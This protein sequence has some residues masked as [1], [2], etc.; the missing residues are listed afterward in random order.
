MRGDG[1]FVLYWMTTARRSGWNFGLQHAANLALELHRPLVILEALR[2]DY[3]WAS[4]R[5]H[6]FVIDGMEDNAA[7]FA[8]RRVLY[9]C[10][11][12]PSPGAG[13]GLI[14]SLAEDA[15]LVV[16]D[17]FPAFF[18]PRMLDAVESR[19]RVRLERVDSNGLLPIR[20]TNR[21]F[22]VA[23]SFRRYL[24]KELSPHLSRFPLADPLAGL[25]LPELSR[26][27]E[28]F[29]TRW[30]SGSPPPIGELPID[31][32]VP[33]VEIRGGETAANARLETFLDGTLDRYAADRNHPDARAESGFSPYLHFGHLSAHHVFARFATRES[34]SVDRLGPVTGGR[35]GWWGM[36]SNAEAFLDQI[37]TWRELGYNRCAHADD[38]DRYETLPEWARKTLEDHADDPRPHLYSLEQ[39]AAA[40]TSDEVWNAAQR[41]LN[42][43]GT[44]HNY[45]RMLWGKR[46][47][48]WTPSPRH[49]LASMIELNNRYAL[50]GRNPNSYSGIFWILGRFD[51][52][53]GPERP[54]FGKVRYMSSASTRKK[55]RLREYLIR[56][57]S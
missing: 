48:E 18:I 39:M 30:F 21:V 12:E 7:S 27:P 47:L 43:E 52:A 31:H 29:E 19:L 23:H 20:A 41:E 28:R 50:D 37:V 9:R 26:L 17:D 38:Y 25:E 44:L 2:C 16:T 54:I 3:R 42:R 33:R 14:E 53:W 10:Y 5:L 15:C 8:P 1:E 32:S 36:S 24:Q 45:L 34:W 11:V 35:Q 6:A 49:A 51:R 46:I 56:Y 40:E 57:G 55:L 13:R 4:E 22:T